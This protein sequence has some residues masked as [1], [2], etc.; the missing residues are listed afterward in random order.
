MT[1]PMNTSVRSRAIVGSVLGLASAFMIGIGGCEE[2]K[3]APEPVASSSAEVE[4]VQE[5]PFELPDPAS[6]PLARV[7][8]WVDRA[9][10]RLPADQ[11]EQIDAWLRKAVQVPVEIRGESRKTLSN[12][13]NLTCGY[14]E[15]MACSFPA[16]L[17]KNAQHFVASTVVC[18]GKDGS[19][20]RRADWKIDPN[21]PRDTKDVDLPV[22]DGLLRDCWEQ[23]TEKLR[24]E[25]IGSPCVVPFPRQVRCA[26]E[27]STCL[28]RCKGAESCEQ[29]CD[30]NRS[31][32]L[33]VCA[34]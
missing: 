12:V 6:V 3:P 27:F 21:T 15:K 20:V 25:V 23:G 32:C 9:R 4:A 31:K 13:G 14:K 7:G 22:D 10:A 29:I 19:T 28:H 11:V 33:S 34:K 26:G 8:D 5:P 16:T 30:A 2:T 18:I 24:M 17:S 1:S